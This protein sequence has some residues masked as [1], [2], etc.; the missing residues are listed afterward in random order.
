MKILM[1][2]PHLKIPGLRGGSI[3]QWELV[4]TLLKSNN[5]IH[6]ICQKPEKI[7]N[8]NNL[9]FHFI[10]GFESLL[11]IPFLTVISFMKV[12]YISLK[13]KVDVI[14]DRGYIFGG[15]G[16][17]AGWILRK[18][19][20]LQ[21]DDN[22]IVAY[23]VAS[24]EKGLIKTN[25][26][27]EKIAKYYL[28]LMFSA[29]NKICTVSGSLADSLSKEYDINREKFEIVPN[30]ADTER[31]NSNIDGS[32][33]R[34]EFKISKSTPVVTFVGEIAKWQGI[35]DIINAVPLVIKKYPHIKFLIVGGYYNNPTKI[36]FKYHLD[37]LVEKHDIKENVIFAG[38]QPYDKIPSIL[39]ASDICLAP[40]SEEGKEHTYGFSPLKIFEYMASGKSIITTN[41]SWI[42]EI[43]DESNAII[44]PPNDSN[45][46]AKEI[47][48]LIDNPN[49]A[50]QLGKNARKKASQKYSWGSIS[51]KLMNVYSKIK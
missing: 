16:T 48:S 39:S 9:H 35:D 49:H 30:G 5:E 47:N 51:E 14:H 42:R 23:K 10:P 25:S 28:R 41:L 17:F 1:V 40:F 33:I 31:F 19:R 4:N 36:A 22:W 45:A 20:I 50:I 8:K 6:I 21:V 44:I 37:K 24:G 43:V 3:H 7:S 2:V 13:Y 34:K 12:L 26:V 32:E 27:M 18:K 29:T 11:L 15:S 38:I 46:L